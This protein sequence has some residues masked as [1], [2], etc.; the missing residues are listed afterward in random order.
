MTDSV[1]SCLVPVTCV[2]KS[3]SLQG[4]LE[5]MSVLLIFVAVLGATLFVTKWIAGYQKQQS[6]NGNIELLDAARLN[7][8]KY[9]QLVRIGETYVAVAV[10]KDTVTTLAQI[11]AKE[12][13]QLEQKGNGGFGEILARL[14]KQDASGEESQGEP[15]SSED[16][17]E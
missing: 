8:N 9:I 6:M 15:T 2:I 11:P 12:I 10:C 4:F 7:G 16:K 1:M 13:K 3:N 14:K 17:A 5:L